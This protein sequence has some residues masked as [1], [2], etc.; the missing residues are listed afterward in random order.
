MI[1]CRPSVYCSRRWIQQMLLDRRIAT[2]DDLTSCPSIKSTVQSLILFPFSSF[3]FHLTIPLFSSS[4][5]LISSLLFSNF[6]TS[7]LINDYIQNDYR[8]IVDRMVWCC[9]EHLGTLI[10]SEFCCLF[11]WI[12]ECLP[13]SVAIS[14]EMVQCLIAALKKEGRSLAEEANI[15]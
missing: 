5:L 14:S 11:N 6:S 2:R 9:E 13:I 3:S 1:A 10:F 7:H 12:S 15:K 4:F 8:Q